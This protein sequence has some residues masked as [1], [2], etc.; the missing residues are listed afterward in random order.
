MTLAASLEPWLA[1]AASQLDAWELFVQTDAG[2]APWFEVIRR[3]IAAA[4]P[5][6][7][8]PIACAL[9]RSPAV[10]TRFLPELVRRGYDVLVGIIWRAVPR[11]TFWSAAAR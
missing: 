5:S 8:S 11:E 2:S 6:T 9:A 4:R 7:R 1:R 3:E 10:A